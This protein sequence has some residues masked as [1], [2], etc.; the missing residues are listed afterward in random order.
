MMHL[1]IFLEIGENISPGQGTA[2]NPMTEGIATETFRTIDGEN[3]NRTP[4]PDSLTDGEP[5]TFRTAGNEGDNTC[6]GTDDGAIPDEERP[7]IIP[8]AG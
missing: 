1:L 6:R 5:G 3:N 4:P 7:D 8:A 2:G